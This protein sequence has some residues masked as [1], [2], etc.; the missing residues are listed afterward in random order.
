VVGN[1]DRE[2]ALEEVV[3]FVLDIDFLY[4]LHHEA[5]PIQRVRSQTPCSG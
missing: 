3:A 5:S 2:A 4:A 1:A